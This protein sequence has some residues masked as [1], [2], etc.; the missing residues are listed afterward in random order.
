MP[1]DWRTAYFEQAQSDYRMLLKLVADEMTCLYQTACITY[2]WQP[3]NWR[4]ASALKLGKAHTR[5]H[6]THLRHS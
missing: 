1:M 3:R 6:T 4:K 5:E 2:R